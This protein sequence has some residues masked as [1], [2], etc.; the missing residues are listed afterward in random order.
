MIPILYNENTTNFASFGIGA[1]ADTLS[2]EVTEE[3]NGV[4]ELV[5]KYPVKG[6]HFGEIKKERLIKAKPNDT[7]KPQ[8][9]PYLQDNYTS[10]RS[11]NDLCTAHFL[12]PYWYSCSYVVKPSYD[13]KSSNGVY[14]G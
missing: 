1:L 3:R 4:Y 10:K 2:C 14:L 13:A 9:F 8:A 6:L 11:C 7:S 5:L 12:R